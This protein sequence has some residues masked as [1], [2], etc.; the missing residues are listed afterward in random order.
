MK[1]NACQQ[2]SWMWWNRWSL[3][4]QLLILLTAS[5]SFRGKKVFLILKTNQFHHLCLMSPQGP[6]FLHIDLQTPSSRSLSGSDISTAASTPS[7]TPA[8]TRSLRKPSRV[9]W[10]FIAWEQS[11]SHTIAIWKQFRVKLRVKVSLS[12]W[13]WTAGGLHAGSALLP[14]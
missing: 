11:Q 2:S 3:Q 4:L 7:S 13:A 10:E 1:N 14:L 6:F 9:Y 8:P 12:V 5:L